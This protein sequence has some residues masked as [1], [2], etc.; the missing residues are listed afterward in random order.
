MESVWLFNAVAVSIPVNC[1]TTQKKLSFK[2]ETVI[3]PAPIDKT[4]KARPKDESKPND[5]KIGA[6]IAAVV[7]ME[8]VEEPWA[9]F[10]TAA[11]KNGKNTITR[12]K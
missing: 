12:S 11:I 8:T 10:K 2:C 1:T 7:I 6:I 4:V 9:D 5:S 3:A